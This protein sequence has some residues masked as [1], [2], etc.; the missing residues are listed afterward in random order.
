VVHV[1]ATATTCCAFGGDDLDVLYITTAAKG[2]PPGGQ[3]PHAGGLFAVDP[4]VKGV[5][6]TPY[7]G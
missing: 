1:P 2:A 5:P 4:S 6:G 7:A 3:E